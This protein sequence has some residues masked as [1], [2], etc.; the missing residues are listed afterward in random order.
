MTL[1]LGP[2]ELTL[3]LRRIARPPADPGAVPHAEGSQRLADIMAT[4]PV[5][6]ETLAKAKRVSPFGGPGLT[7]NESAHSVVDEIA[8]FGASLP[9]PR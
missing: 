3:T 8:K 9:P 2:Y 5:D 7:G 6:D 4:L 1:R